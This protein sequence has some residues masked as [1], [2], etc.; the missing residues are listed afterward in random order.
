MADFK[1]LESL[2]RSEAFHGADKTLRSGR[3]WATSVRPLGLWL[4]FQKSGETPKLKLGKSGKG[5]RVFDVQ[6]SGAV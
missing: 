6:F 5:G 1:R 2:T 4:K 3:G